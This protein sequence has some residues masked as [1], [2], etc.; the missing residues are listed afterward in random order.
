M[1][2]KWNVTVNVKDP[3]E[4]IDKKIKERIKNSEIELLEIIRTHFDDLETKYNDR[5]VKLNE[6]I[7]N[8]DTSE[9]QSIIKDSLESIKR[10]KHDFTHK[11]AE[12]RAENLGISN[13][14]QLEKQDSMLM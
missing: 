8:L 7:N 5:K 11:L 3:N 13:R 9:N 4:D 14:I 12:K 6:T 2:L 1:G 10:E